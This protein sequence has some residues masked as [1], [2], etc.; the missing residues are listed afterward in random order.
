MKKSLTFILLTL[1]M[2]LLI[3]SP[4]AGVV[5]DLLRSD[6]EKAMWFMVII[7]ASSGIISFALC[8]LLYFKE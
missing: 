1:A 2:M 4:N 7:T 3:V 5:V 8:K 6:S